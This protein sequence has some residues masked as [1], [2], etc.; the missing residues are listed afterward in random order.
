M[1]AS[2]LKIKYYYYILLLYNNFLSSSPS[3]CIFLFVHRIWLELTYS[4]RDIWVELAE[5]LETRPTA[6]HASMPPS[7][8]LNNDKLDRMI[9]CYCQNYILEVDIIGYLEV[10][11]A[12][13]SS[14]ELKTNK[15]KK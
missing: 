7:S 13:N 2:F 5:P 1:G 8:D 11:V 6:R 10:D 15:L 3:S 9:D 12:T 14:N 4:F